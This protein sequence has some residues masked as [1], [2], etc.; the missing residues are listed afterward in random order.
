MR[1]VIG[2]I[3]LMAVMCFGCASVSGVRDEPLTTGYSQTYEAAFENVMKAAREATIESGL[4]IE[5]A[6]KIDGKTYMIIGKAGTSAFSWGELVRVVVQEQSPNLV[7]VR[8]LTKKKLATNVVAKGDYS[9]SILS[10]IEL[11]LNK[12]PC[13]SYE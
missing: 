2:G 8:V 5:E 7:A 3:S 13:G 12:Q 1:K 4:K 9:R 11:K 6:N 10:S